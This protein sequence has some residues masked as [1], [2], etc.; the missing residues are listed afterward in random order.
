[1]CFLICCFSFN[2]LGNDAA[3]KAF[4]DIMIHHIVYSLY[5]EET[6]KKFAYWRDNTYWLPNSIISRTK[7][8]F[9]KSY[10]TQSTSLIFQLVPVFSNNV[11]LCGNDFGR[12]NEQQTIIK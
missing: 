9:L 2:I 6:I 4:Y 5:D 10:V 12:Q 1:M 7:L 3:F 11:M 8:R